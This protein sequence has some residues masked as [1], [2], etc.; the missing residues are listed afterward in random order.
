MKYDIL[1]ELIPLLEE[2]EAEN[3]SANVYS[4]DLDGFKSWVVFNNKQKGVLD[5][6]DWEGKKEGRSAESVISTLIVHLNRYARSYSK[7][8]I[9]GSEF[10]TQE[11][12]IYLINLRAF[13]EMS[14]MDL[15]KK[16]VHE[17]PAGMQVINRLIFQGW[18][19]QK[20]SEL[21]R[22]SKLVKITD[23][24]IKVLEEQMGEIRKATQIVAGDLT[25]SEKMELIRL[26]N[27]LNDFHQPIYDKNIEIE[28][29]LDKVLQA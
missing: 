10:S 28:H 17:K 15:V 11:D 21:D 24:G 5:E 12:F 6:P 27:K 29:L 22:R 3:L 26:L 14:K 2:F 1:K 9:F 8:A 7:S 19:S 4:N 13:G 25:R 16:N 20:D 23:K 18:V